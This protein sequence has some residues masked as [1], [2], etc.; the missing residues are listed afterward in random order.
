MKNIR[1]KSE[2]VFPDHCDDSMHELNIKMRIG[3][4]A[5]ANYVVDEIEN[6]IKADRILG[7][8]FPSLEMR[9]N[10]IISVIE[11]LKK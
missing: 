5:G 8:P 10:K 6:I 9:Y 1:E 4:I 2:D 3:F 11:Q 7:H